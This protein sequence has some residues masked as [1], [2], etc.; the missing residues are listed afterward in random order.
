[1]RAWIAKAYGLPVK[2]LY[3]QSI[4][5]DFK[6]LFFQSLHQF[7]MRL[8]FS[9]LSEHQEQLPNTK[10]FYYGCNEERYSFLEKI[11]L[12]QSYLYE[13][14]LMAFGN[15]WTNT[16]LHAVVS[17]SFQAIVT[18]RVL[19]SAIT[20]VCKSLRLLLGPLV[21]EYLKILASNFALER[22][23]ALETDISPVAE[24]QKKMLRTRLQSLQPPSLDVSFITLSLTIRYCT[25]T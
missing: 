2:H 13:D 6:G 9:V 23:V 22:I 12:D 8:R 21:A 18:G 10:S 15:M 24:E 11:L 17:D 4:K 3:L 1:M 14:V 16:L 5:S 25:W 7:T 19:G 20:T